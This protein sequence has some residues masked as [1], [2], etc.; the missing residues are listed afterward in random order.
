MTSHSRVYISVNNDIKQK[1]SIFYIIAFIRNI[2][3]WKSKL[4][5]EFFSSWVS[6]IRDTEIYQGFLSTIVRLTPFKAIDHFEIVR[7]EKLSSNS[8]HIMRD[9][10]CTFSRTVTFPVVSICQE[11]KCRRVSMLMHAPS[12]AID[13][14]TLSSQGKI[15]SIT[16]FPPSFCIIFAFF[17][18]IPVNILLWLKWVFKQGISLA[19]WQYYNKICAYLKLI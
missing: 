1:Y 10:S 8:T 5:S 13:W 4:S 14:P 12:W 6:G 18:I 2:C 11:T 19:S 16:N 7:L 17:S 9:Q 15:F 3:S